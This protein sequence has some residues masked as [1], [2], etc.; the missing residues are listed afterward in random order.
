MYNLNSG[1]EENPNFFINRKTDVEDTLAFSAISLTLIKIT[2]S[3]LLTM[4][5]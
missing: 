3:K 5:L 2:L 1:K 4:Y